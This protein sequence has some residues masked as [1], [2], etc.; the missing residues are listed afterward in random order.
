MRIL[1]EILGNAKIILS[2]NAQRAIIK[3]RIRYK[4]QPVMRG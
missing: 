1:I 3:I 2:K 4:K